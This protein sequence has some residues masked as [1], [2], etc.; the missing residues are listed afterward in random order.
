MVSDNQKQGASEL[1]PMTN[2]VT[3][4]DHELFIEE[5]VL[6]DNV[7]QRTLPI[8]RISI[9][10][11]LQTYVCRIECYIIFPYVT[12]YRQWWQFI[13]RTTKFKTF[14]VVLLLVLTVSIS[15]VLVISRYTQHNGSNI[16]V[17]S[18]GKRFI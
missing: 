2:N 14:G 1:V 4:E 7:S 9:E 18:Q 16:I 5:A 6:V 13:G 15:T 11:V 12:V 3:Q 8:S 10:P 17:K